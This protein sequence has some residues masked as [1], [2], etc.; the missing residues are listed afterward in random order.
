MKRFI[1]GFLSL[2]TTTLLAQFISLHSFSAWAE[3][4]ILITLGTDMAEALNQRWQIESRQ[5][6]HNENI[7]FAEIDEELIPWMSKIAHEKFKRCGGF[8]VHESKES[9]LPTPNFNAEIVDYTIEQHDLVKRLLVEV[10]EIKIRQTIEK[11]SS[12]HNRYYQSEHGVNSQEWLYQH[13]IELSKHRNDVKVEK[14]VH[15]SWPQPTIVLTIEGSDLPDEIVVLGGHADSINQW[16]L[17][18]SRA[19]APGADDNASGI[20][21]VTESIRL[22]LASGHK[23]KRTLQFMAYAAEE[24]GLRGSG[25]IAESYKKLNKKVMGV[26]QF[27]M[28]NF[29]GSDLNIFLVED[30]TN[31]DQNRFLGQLIDTYLQTPWGSTKCGYACS[32]HGSWTKNGFFASAAFEA[33]KSDMNKSLHTPEDTLEKSGGTALHATTFSKLALAYAIEMGR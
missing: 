32:D 18:K 9:L 30:F 5:L 7:S 11:L 6:E 21:T 15:K 26:L 12:F 33:N 20:A 27:D 28:T 29:K 25:E 3:E 17:F 22:L 16:S 31:S 19:R 24:V 14:R 8:M 1:K 13:W 10:E 23:P 2:S 4:K